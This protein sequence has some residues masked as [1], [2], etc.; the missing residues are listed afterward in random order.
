MGTNRNFRRLEERVNLVDFSRLPEHEQEHIYRS[1]IEKRKFDT[2]EEVASA[3]IDFYQKNKKVLNYYGCK[4][5][6]G[7]HLT[8]GGRQ[9]KK[10]IKK[11]ILKTLDESGK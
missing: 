10:A 6:G 8:S 7:Y 1:C 5:C 2:V 3:L 9:R 11:M 4:H